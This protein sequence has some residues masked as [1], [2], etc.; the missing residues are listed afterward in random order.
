VVLEECQGT[1]NDACSRLS[2]EALN[3]EIE[4]RLHSVVEALIWKR[5]SEGELWHNTEPDG[6]K[7]WIE[8]PCEM[9]TMGMQR[10]R[11]EMIKQPHKKS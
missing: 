11:R 5:V 3:E 9:G 6:F 8:R 2:Y 7:D 4:F 10:T 1:M